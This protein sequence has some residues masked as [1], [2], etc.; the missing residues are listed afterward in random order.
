MAGA[1]VKGF[2][3]IDRLAVKKPFSKQIL[4]RIGNGLAVRIGPGSVGENAGKAARRRAR[5]ANA[6]ARLN[7][8][9]TA[10]SHF[11]NRIQNGPVERVRNGRHQSPGASRRQ[12]SIRIQRDYIPDWQRQ[13]SRP[14][15][16]SNRVFASQILVQFFNFS[17]FPFL[18]DPVALAFRPNPLPVKEQKMGTRKTVIERFNTALNCAMQLRIPGHDLLSRIAEIREQAEV[19]IRILIGEEANLQFFQLL[20]NNLKARQHHRNHHHRGMFNRQ[21]TVKIEFRQRVRVE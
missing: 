1:L 21:A 13:I 8:G 19:Q 18:S 7:D 11:G 14:F 16:I 6:D 17:A 5:K 3:V 15:D 9:E 10:P 12:L 2:N 4:L 20:A